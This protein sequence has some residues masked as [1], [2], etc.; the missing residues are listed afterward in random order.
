M[1]DVATED[2]MSELETAVRLLADEEAAG[3][4]DHEYLFH[5]NSGGKENLVCSC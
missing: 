3:E 1:Y 2:S 5:W 4:P